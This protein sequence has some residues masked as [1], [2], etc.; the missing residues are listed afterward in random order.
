MGSGETIQAF[1]KYRLGAVDQHFHQRS[2]PRLFFAVRLD[3]SAHALG[4][5]REPRSEIDNEL[6]ER[7]VLLVVTE[8]GHDHR[9]VAGA[10]FAMGRAQTPGMRPSIGLDESRALGAGKMA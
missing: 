3:P 5:A 10:R 4:V 9:D 6:F 1:F 8:V 7:T 2:P